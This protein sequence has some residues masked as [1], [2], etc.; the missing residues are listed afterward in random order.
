MLNW[1]LVLLIFIQIT[2]A[3]VAGTLR[4]TRD[5]DA[6]VCDLGQVVVTTGEPWCI[7]YCTMLEAHPKWNLCCAVLPVTTSAFPLCIQYYSCSTIN[8]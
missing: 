3:N 7:K 4:P 8:E 2:L 5:C 1:Y 6:A